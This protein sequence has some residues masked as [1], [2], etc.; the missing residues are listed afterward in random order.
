VDKK[1]INYWPYAIVASIFLMIVA[2]TYT[3]KVAFDNPVQMD[4]FY[5]SE[6]HNVDD[7]INDILAL[8]K[9][10]DAKY[11]VVLDGKDFVQGTNAIRLQILDKKSQTPIKDAKIQLKI[12][13]P[14]TLKYD[15]ELKPLSLKDGYY[16]FK[17]FQLKKPG[18]WQVLTKVK[19]GDLVGFQK[20]EVNA[21]KQG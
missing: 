3:V 7:K 15:L 13:R 11:S 5:F 8:Q 21:T 6:Y 2:I 4:D 17:P 9:K 1:K 10:F 12:T 20:I 14:N 19:V 18:R 16:I